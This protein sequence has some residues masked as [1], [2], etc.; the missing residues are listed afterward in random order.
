MNKSDHEKIK[1]EL[2]RLGFD[3]DRGNNLEKRL[4][5]H[6][7]IRT[8]SKRRRDNVIAELKRKERKRKGR[9]I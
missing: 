4:F 8:V 2:K 5:P 6:I 7:P 3:S 1:R 9:G